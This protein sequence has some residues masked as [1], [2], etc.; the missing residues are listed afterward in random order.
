MA[1]PARQRLLAGFEDAAP[2]TTPTAAP[3]PTPNAE[4]SP[5]TPV[6]AS[7]ASP[8][9][10]ISDPPTHGVVPGSL[11]GKTVY[12]IDS[13][14]LIYQVFH[15]M[16]EM[17]SPSGLPV[18]AVHGFLGDIANLLEQ[19]RP[20]YLFCAF[21]HPGDTFR[22]DLFVEY[23]EQRESMPDDLQTQI[24]L[25]QQLI[26]A[27]GLPVLSCPGFEA[28][29]VLATIARLAAEQGGECVLVTTDKDCRQ[30]IT[31]RVRMLNVRKN[32]FFDAAA[33]AA[34]WGIRPD[35]VVD[36]QTL[37]GDSVDNI[38]GVP[39][40]GPKI[41]QE[42]LQKYQTL[43]GIYAHVGELKAGK[44]RDNLIAGREQTVVSRQLVRLRDDA[45]IE[46][47]WPG[48]R[49][50]HA[51][52]TLLKSL[53]DELGFR[54]LADRLAQLAQAAAPPA[55]DD[56]QSNYRTITTDSELDELV[57]ALSQAERIAVDT[58][59]TS[60][61]P[62]HAQLVGLSFAWGAGEACYIPLRAPA[63]EPQWDAQQVLE[64]LRPVLES[65]AIRKAGQNLKYDLIVLRAAGVT[66][67]GLEFD[68]MV[69]DYL[70]EPGARI[71]NMDELARRYLHHATIR[72]EEL[73]GTGRQQKRMDEVPVPLITQ[74]AAE[75]ADVPWRLAALLGPRLAEQQLDRLFH[76]VEMPLVEVLAELEFNGIK[77]DVPRL[78]E[79]S[80]QF[81]CEMQRL[82]AEL[83]AL[84]GRSFNVDSPSQLAEILFEEL[85]L[86]VIKKTKTGKSTDAS[87]L[88]ELAPLHPLPAKVVEYRQI[89]KLKS[90]YL[91]ALPDLVHP[92]TG[93]VHSSFKQDVA[94]TGRLSSTEPN[95]QNIPVRTETG[96]LIR[97][98]FLAGEPGWQLLTAD[99]SQIELR[100]LAHFSGDETLRTAFARNEDIHTL[101]ASQVYG[102]ALDEVTKDQRRS[103]K[104]IN[105][106]VI[107]G[108]SAFGLSKSLGI[109]KDEA[110]A[111][112]AA[113]FARYPGVDAF[114]NRTLD[115]ARRQGYVTTILGRRRPVQGVR[116]ASQRGDSR[117]RTLPE[118]IAINTV[119]QGSAA[120]LIKLAMIGVH[121][122]L[123]HA[124]LPARLLLQIH[125][126]LVFE[127]APEALERLKALVVEEMARAGDLTVSL[128][129]DVRTGSNWAACEK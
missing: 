113:Y 106:G 107:Y 3:P 71:H 93:R 66:L 79:L 39:L 53:C 60:T 86:P 29:D 74:Y 25:I 65:P 42:L 62:R 34:T 92:A 40:I 21:D 100:V 98:A 22:H 123:Q 87:V 55:V 5:A 128:K 108:Q 90:T 73:I 33:L 110:A 127:S 117:Q 111:F 2:P 83:H 115:D 81:G 51:R 102:V 8:T 105:F 104:A 64:R 94:A 122:R 31:D 15:A 36:F 23:K 35:Q 16:P 37:V 68:T 89:A 52:P 61:R 49:L 77:I 78:Q 101:V 96:R 43:E 44:R 84:A 97:A 58:E 50:A 120:D 9:V 18:G 126:E 11:A 125:D 7:P 103:A 54:R 67:R 69:A 41:A 124:G 70:L 63:G 85:K 30:L 13:H 56:W 48:A 57:A 129:V 19:R 45:P 76:D 20:D 4:E 91:D 38:P 47:D 121:R 88:E 6:S 116:D 12:V 82:E 99:Y 14:S 27:L 114:M 72:I 24:P 17:T 59:T 109:D 80:E 119:I 46:L 32:E 26:E 118:R 112:I 75:D 28:D 10:A 1:K 95:L